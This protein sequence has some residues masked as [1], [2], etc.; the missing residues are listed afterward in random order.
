MHDPYKEPEKN[1]ESGFFLEF[2]VWLLFK[3]KPS[4]LKRLELD[5]AID[6]KLRGLDLEFE[7]NK[8]DT[9][10][11]GFFTYSCFRLVNLDEPFCPLK[12]G[13]DVLGNWLRTTGADYIFFDYFG[14]NNIFFGMHNTYYEALIFNIAKRTLEEFAKDFIRRCEEEDKKLEGVALSPDEADALLKM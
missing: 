1:D 13:A 10:F 8:L 9:D 12:D 11:E 5:K 6:F 7:E 14:L 2:R 4:E 3:E